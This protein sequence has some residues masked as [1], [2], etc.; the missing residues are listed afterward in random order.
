MSGNDKAYTPFIH[1][2]S[3]LPEDVARKPNS[4]EFYVR[5]PARFLKDPNIS[6]EAKLLREVLGAFAD[7]HSKRTHVRAVRIQRL[8]RCGR[9]KRER[10]QRELH[11]T[12]WLR[13]DWQRDKRGRWARRIYVLC[14]PE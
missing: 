7:G 11:K 8:M 14:E 4:R 10:A 2:K 6:P 13:L 12:G 1:L 9:G 3:T 5:T